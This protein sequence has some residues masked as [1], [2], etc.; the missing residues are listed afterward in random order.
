MG[1]KS[2]KP[3]VD[4]AQ[5]V[6]EI[7]EKYEVE[8]VEDTDADVSMMKLVNKFAFRRVM[9]EKEELDNLIEGYKCYLA[10]A[11]NPTF[12]SKAVYKAIDL[13]KQFCSA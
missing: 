9:I 11:K 8:N 4:L 3:C 13:Y 2:S 6:K 7:A 10:T 12:D 1:L 5:V